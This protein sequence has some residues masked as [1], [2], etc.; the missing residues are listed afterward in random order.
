MYEGFDCDG[1]TWDGHL[2]D[3]AAVVTKLEYTVD[4]D[5]TISPENKQTEQFNLG[6]Y[7]ANVIKTFSATLVKAIINLPDLIIN[8]L[9]WLK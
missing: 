9:D 6:E 4:P 5:E 1:I 2:S 8:G 3:H 7:I